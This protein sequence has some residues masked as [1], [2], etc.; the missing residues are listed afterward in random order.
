MTKQ[1]TACGNA[2][3]QAL[4]RHGSKGSRRERQ[5]WLVFNAEFS[6]FD[7]SPGIPSEAL[8]T[9]RGRDESN[10]GAPQDDANEGR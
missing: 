10:R 3:Y 7:G 5:N 8:T 1:P 4:R 9:G 6:D 2:N